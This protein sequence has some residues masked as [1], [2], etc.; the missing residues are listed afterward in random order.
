AGVQ[1]DGRFWTTLRSGGPGRVELIACWAVPEG[2]IDSWDGEGDV[3]GTL[4]ARS[5]LVARWRT[6]GDAELPEGATHP[7][8]VALFDGLEERGIDM[9]LDREIEVRQTVLTEG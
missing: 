1:L 3:T 8:V 5:E 7:A 6:S 9:R 4:P 2:V